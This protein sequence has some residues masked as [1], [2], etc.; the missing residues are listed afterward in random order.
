MPHAQVPILLNNP[1]RV[2][3]LHRQ[4]LHPTNMGTIQVFE[5][6]LLSLFRDMC[7]QPA[8][9]RR[10]VHIMSGPSVPHALLDEVD[11]KFGGLPRVGCAAK[12]V[13][14]LHSDE[15]GMWGGSTRVLVC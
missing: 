10:F 13:D 12:V 6:H 9:E 7:V 15:G 5:P 8:D 11:N 4:V 2:T 3:H 1:R 14:M